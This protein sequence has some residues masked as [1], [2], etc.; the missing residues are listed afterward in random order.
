[1]SVLN[2]CWIWRWLRLPG[3]LC[4]VSVAGAAAEEASVD[5]TLSPL[6]VTARREAAVAP[7]PLAVTLP[8][9]GEGPRLADALRLAPGLVVQD[10]FGGFDPPRLAVR[11]S[12]LQ[13]AP[14]SRGLALSLFGLPMNAADGSFNLALLEREWLGEVGLVRGPAAGVP[15]L[16]GGLSFAPAVFVPGAALSASWG[17]RDSVELHGRGAFAGDGFELIGRAAYHDADGWR[18]HSKQRRESF[19]AALRRELDPATELTVQALVASPFHEVPGP[20]TKSQALDAPKTNNAATLRDRPRRETEYAQFNARISRRLEDVR[21]HA[22]AGVAGADDV[23][24]Q[25]LPN[26]ISD[27]RSRDVFF[28]F[29]A[30]R[31]WAA[32]SQ[33]TSVSALLQSGWWDMRRYRTNQGAKG[34]LIGDF[35]LR[36]TTFTGALDHR[37]RLWEGQR[38]DFGMSL[39]GARRGYDDRLAGGPEGDFSGFRLAPR[40]AWTWEAAPGLSLTAGWSRGY[41]PPT[42]QDLIST[43]G[44]PP[45]IGGADLGWQRADS[46]ELGAQ[47][48]HER[49]SWSL[50]AYHSRWENEFLRL[51]DGTGAGRGTVNAGKTLHQGVEAGLQ[52]QLYSRAG[53][54]LTAS[55]P[56]LVAGALRRRSGVWPGQAGRSAAASGRRGAAGV[57]A[58]RVV[59][60]ARLRLALRTDPCGPRQQPVLWRQRAVV[61]AHGT[62]A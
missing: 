3:W 8:A 33:R 51:V 36:P 55:V 59:S 30:E 6:L 21:F 19:H 34:A 10:S 17:S 40:I 54:E 60:G 26:G 25:L 37:M 43:S 62:A 9:A 50:T 53:W 28:Q 48:A 16:G 1:M 58:R 15:A 22:A 20:L 29:G 27:T 57:R 24:Y 4:A 5:A 2:G 39:L 35:R 42:Y 38:V 31:D 12:G 7:S 49:W 13:S 44:V 52:C 47:G 32:E 23:F 11:G 18:G 41:E 45:V 14:T 61:A 46:F 56:H